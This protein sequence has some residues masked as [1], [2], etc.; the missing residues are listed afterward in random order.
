MTMGFRGAREGAL[1]FGWRG[2]I[3]ERVGLTLFHEVVATLRNAFQG[4]MA[5]GDAFYFFDGM[6]FLEEGAAEN[7]EFGAG[8]VNFV[9][10]IGGATAGG[11]GLAHGAEARA[12]FF[13]EA[14]E[15]FEGEA[16]LDLDV[17][18]L[19]KIGPG[20]EHGGGEIAIVG[21]KDEAG[22]GVIEG[23]DGIDAF[24]KAAEEIAEGAAAFGIGKGGNNFWRFVEE[25]IDVIFFGFDE[26]AGGFDLVFGGIGFGAEFGDDDA[27]DADLAGEDKFLG[28]ASGGDAGVGDYFL[29]AVEHAGRRIADIGGR[30][31]DGE[32][33]SGEK[34]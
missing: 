12:G 15:F 32:E 23:A 9:P 34:V 7:V 22:V 20:F 30:E 10:E 5:Q 1:E 19:R 4:E 27:V 33:K 28:V 2:G 26:A 14:I 21:K 13:A 24:G 3:A 17:I 25:E 11:I 8:G 18:D 6:Q 31:L 16:A 29:E